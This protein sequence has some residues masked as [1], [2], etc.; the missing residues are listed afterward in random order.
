[1]IKVENITKKY[2]S[3]AIEVVALNNVSFSLGKTGLVFI[4]GKSGSGKTTMLNVLGG[5][6]D[7]DSGNIYFE[8]TDKKICITSKKE[9]E[10]DS[11][12]NIDIGYIFQDYYLIDDWSVRDNI[13]IALKQQKNESL[14]DEKIEKKLLDILEY[15]ELNGMEKRTPAELSGGQAQRIAIARALIKEPSIILADE[16]TGNLDSKSGAKIFDLLKDISKKCLV[17]V[18][19][20]D[21]NS[22][23]KY[24][25]RIIRMSD[26]CIVEDICNKKMGERYEVVVQDTTNAIKE[27]FSSGS[28]DKIKEFLYS[29]ILLKKGKHLTYSVEYS[30]Y[31]NLIE[32]EKPFEKKSNVQAKRI[33]FATIFRLALNSLKKRKIRLGITISIFAISLCFLQILLQLCVADIGKSEAEYLFQNQKNIFFVTEKNYINEYEEKSNLQRGD[34]KEILLLIEKYWEDNEKMSCRNNVE[35]SVPKEDGSVDNLSVILNEKNDSLKII[36]GS[37]IKSENDIYV[38]DFLVEYLRL[39]KN[40]IGKKIK[41]LGLDFNICGIVDTD[42]E[43]TDIISKIKTNSMSEIDNYNFEFEYT[44]VFCAE[45]IVDY[46][47]K[48]STS[49]KVELSDFAAYGETQYI[50]NVIEYGSVENVRDNG[51]L[52]C[53]RYP[54]KANEIMISYDYALT[55]GV[56]DSD[57]NEI[58]SYAEFQFRDMNNSIYEG[59]FDGRTN[60]YDLFKDIKVVGVFESTESS[61]VQAWLCNEDYKKLKE[62]YFTNFYTLYRLNIE[63]KSIE[64]LRYVFNESYSNKVYVEEPIARSIQYIYEE[65]DNMF[66]YGVLLVIIFVLLVLLLTLSFM[67]YN[68]SD[69]HKKIGILRALGIDKVTVSKM[70]VY[71]SIVISLLSF[72]IS[73]ILNIVAFKGINSYLNEEYDFVVKFFYQNGII[74]ASVFGFAIIVGVLAVILPIIS[75]SGQKPIKLIRGNS[76]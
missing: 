60:M 46:I 14:T 52:I 22:A 67:S 39:G 5:L 57:E 27:T 40:P 17:V 36:D 37:F 26:G 38:T 16:P 21:E 20:H 64:D 70:F 1:M 4:L 24:G 32:E 25:D 76:Y 13:T 47:K 71:E 45:R 49:L 61:S 68:V 8:K 10:M 59:A 29:R 11:L 6:D 72:V 44:N 30:C 9:E 23:F 35:I 34:S 74:I 42:Y 41:M 18:V 62:S 15:V 50:D 73:S 51:F 12:R 48:N 53:G 65:R 7:A 66:V 75:M 63:N 69:N 28:M 19:S 56:Y 3:K 33:D 31:D 55:K 54:E 58:V 2:T 43:E